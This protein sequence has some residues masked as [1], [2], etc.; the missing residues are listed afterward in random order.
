M[1]QRLHKNTTKWNENC[2]QMER[3][4]PLWPVGTKK[5]EFPWTVV[6]V[7][8]GKQSSVWT[9]RWGILTVWTENVGLMG[10]VPGQ[11]ETTKQ[12]ILCLELLDPTILM[13]IWL[14]A[15]KAL[16]YFLSNVVI[17]QTSSCVNRMRRSQ[18]FPYRS[19]DSRLYV[20]ILKF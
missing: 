16:G 11:I 13:Q 12:K 7:C 4:F 1:A 10:S 14:S 17:K 2:Y 9:A 19:K 8:S 20:Q 18:L 15:I 5:V 6:R 3:S